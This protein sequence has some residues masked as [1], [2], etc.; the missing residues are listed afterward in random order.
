M[1]GTHN[2]ITQALDLYL[3][4]YI[5][6]NMKIFNTRG[7]RMFALLLIRIIPVYRNINLVA[8]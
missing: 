5:A 2:A 6:K 1:F 7:D 4:F 3:G 8:F